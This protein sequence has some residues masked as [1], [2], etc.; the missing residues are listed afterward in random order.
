MTM[1][2]MCNGP[3]LA[4]LHGARH[5]DVLLGR[6]GVSRTRWTISIEGRMT[7]VSDQEHD[8]ACAWF[9]EYLDGLGHAYEYE[10]DLGIPTLPDFRVNTPSGLIVCEVKSFRAKPMPISGYYVRDMRE[11][12]ATVRRQIGSA[13]K[14]LK[15]L[16]GRG[17]PLVV[18]LADPYRT[19]APLDQAVNAIYGDISALLTSTDDGTTT[20]EWLAGRNGQL[21]NYHPHVSGVLV[22]RHGS[23]QN[24]QLRAW[25]PSKDDLDGEAFTREMNSYVES[26]ANDLGT[27]L[28]ATYVEAPGRRAT[29][30]PEGV[31]IGDRAYRWRIANDGTTITRGPA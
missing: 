4:D 22:L 31:F 24:D 6:H 23:D 11:V 25:K 18:V 3:V 2:P 15:P 20:T 19:G 30:L 21:R 16:S 10:P 13:A 12:L 8:A 26:I 9:R 14:Q 5:H 27:Y 17:I 28:E 7:V 29:P 1:T